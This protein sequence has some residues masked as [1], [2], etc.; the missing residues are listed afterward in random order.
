MRCANPQCHADAEDLLRGTLQAVEFETPP[1]KRLLYE[2]GGFPVCSARTRFFWLC[3]AC[4]RLF[5]IRKWNASGVILQPAPGM[6]PDAA[7]AMGKKSASPAS[8]S[9]RNPGEDLYRIA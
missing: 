7:S 9:D 5:T 1:E 2:S 6:D 4:S 3:P 8:P